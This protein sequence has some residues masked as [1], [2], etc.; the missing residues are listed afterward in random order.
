MHGLHA[1]PNIAFS[2]P[3]KYQYPVSNMSFLADSN[4]WGS[5]RKPRK[6][7]IILKQAKIST[8]PPDARSSSGLYSTLEDPDSNIRL[9][10]IDTDHGDVSSDGLFCTLSIV[11]PWMNRVPY[12]CLSY[13]WGDGNSLREVFVRA[14]ASEYHK[15]SITANLHSALR[16]LQQTHASRYL[17]IDALCINQA[18]PQERAS[19]VS[20]MRE[21]YDKASGVVVWLG[22]G[23]P[24]LSSAIT[25]IAA[26]STRFQAETA[27]SPESIARPSGLQLR[28]ADIERLKA[29]TDLSSGDDY[30]LVAHFFSIPYFRRVW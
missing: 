29:Y 4:T 24:K 8:Y 3:T 10:R 7:T 27:R 20:M 1:Q 12:E 18:D 17:W 28:P 5:P 30:A 21:I 2:R 13:C 15:I 16:R 9:L 11:Q 6:P 22:E 23:T 26:I 14:T 19:Q 25:S